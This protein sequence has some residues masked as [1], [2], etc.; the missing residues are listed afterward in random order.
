MAPRNTYLMDET[1]QRRL[2]DHDR[3][4]IKGSTTWFPGEEPEVHWDFNRAKEFELLGAFLDR[5]SDL[6]FRDGKVT[7]EEAARA[8]YGVSDDYL[9][10]RIAT[11]HLNPASGFNKTCMNGQVCVVD[12]DGSHIIRDDRVRVARERYQAAADKFQHRV[13][14][15]TVSAG[16]SLNAEQRRSLRIAPGAEE[17]LK[18]ITEV[19]VD[20]TMRQTR[21]ALGAGE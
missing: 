3:Q 18:Q 21:R 14:K 10:G 17:Q 2:A 15:T 7:L 9:V 16:K 11:T 8:T 19:V 13:T 6:D 1:V 5:F 20:A 4:L 12:A